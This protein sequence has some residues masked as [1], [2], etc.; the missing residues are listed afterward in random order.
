MENIDQL[1]SEEQIPNLTESQLK[2]LNNPKLLNQFIDWTKQ[3]KINN[4]FNPEHFYDYARAFLSKT[5]PMLW[6]ELPEEDKQEDIKQGRSLTGKYMWPDQF[7]IEGHPFP[8][9]E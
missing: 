4:P 6:D 9:R 5:T 8:K 3:Y 1:I 2:I 7:K